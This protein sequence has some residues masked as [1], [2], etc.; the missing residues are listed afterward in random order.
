MSREWSIARR[1]LVAHA[2]SIVV[3][4]MFVGTA[5]FVDARDH[6]FDETRT[7]MLSVAATIADN[8]LTLEASAS[9]DPSA[10]LQA[11]TVAVTEDAKLDFITI[12][13]PDG[14]RWTHPTPSEIG[15][16]YS[17][18]IARALA[19]RPFTEI[20]TG[21]LGPSVRAVA[22]V[23]DASG[24]VVALVAA[25]VTTSNVTIALN[26]RL[27]ALLALAA[28]LLVAGSLIS[29]ALGRYLQRVT[30]GW[31]PERLAQLFVYYDS[32]LRS[33]REGLVLVDLTGKL[34]LYNDQA[35]H[36]LGIPPSETN[37]PSTA[38]GELNL[39]PALGALLQSGRRTQ[40]EVFVT[41]T[42]VLV[43]N[44][45]PAVPPSSTGKNK[46]AARIGSVATIRDHTDLQTLGTE[47]QSMRT[48][49]DA[50]RAQTHEHSNRLHTI[51]SLMELGR[52]QEAL[53]YATTD[54][55]LSQQLTDDMVSSVDEP[56]ISALIMGKAAQANELGITLTVTAEGTI[57]G[58]EL[59]VH[60]LVTV[61]GNLIDNAL[62]AAASAPPPR[63]VTV[64][65]S[66]SP[67]C[68]T[69]EVAD[70]GPGIE[71]DAA[72]RVMQLGYSTKDSA[73]YGR[74]LGL[75]LVRQ[76]VERLGGTLAVSRRDGAVFTVTIP[77]TTAP[78]VPLATAGTDIGGP[79][80]E[81]AAGPAGP[82]QGAPS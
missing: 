62:D 51:V 14:T 13:A 3:L 80:V 48:L 71:T 56:V 9:A 54:L 45:E 38:L 72:E 73:G 44:Q 79:A 10:V 36:L 20:N 16:P 17:G 19:G 25:G 33:V 70:S 81:R 43:V 29:L 46:P 50:L 8:P 55:E 74:G 5:M 78:T 68:V 67:D 60:D 76:A 28:G 24:S 53:D 65:V 12:M 59:S 26:A 1:L 27:P 15:R 7:R 34:V 37:R 42:R 31:G 32:V 21:T 77:T 2:L 64:S 82:P 22:P 18:T 69:V 66:R 47:L 30:L 75:A 41:D 63:R 40:D 11:Y 49:S 4:T 57:S 39:P 52:T 58:S 23:V 35:A 61:L 6:G